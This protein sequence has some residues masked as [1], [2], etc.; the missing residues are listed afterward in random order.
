MTLPTA[1]RP[2]MSL[3]VPPALRTATTEDGPA[4]WRL[5]RDTGVLDLNTPYAYLLL[6]DHFR[7]T[8]IVAE[9]GGEV[10]GFV[11]AYVLPAR[12]EVVFV[13]QIG[14]AAAARGQGL[15]LRL[16]LRLLESPA[17]RGVWELQATVTPDNEPSARLFR[18]LARQL[19]C[20]CE[21]QHDR[22]PAHLF[23]GD[24][25]EPEHLFVVGPLPTRPAKPDL[26][27]A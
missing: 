25:H 18:A 9:Q 27:P 22:Y 10:V 2:R 3:D 11:A 15:A 23:P 20:R 12:P 8:C 16:L 4:I 6:A 17:C 24:A 26:E 5:V 13:W 14:V 1:E 19:G 21:V 7:D